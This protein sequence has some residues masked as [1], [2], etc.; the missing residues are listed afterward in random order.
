[1]FTQCAV[2]Q[3]GEVVAELRSSRDQSAALQHLGTV[4]CVPRPRAAAWWDFSAGAW[5]EKPSAPHPRAVWDAKHKVWRQVAQE[6]QWQ[7]VREL[8]NSLLARSDWTALPDTPLSADQRGLWMAY[9]Q[10]LR[11]VTDQADPFNI[12]WPEPP[13]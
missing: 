12:V 11:D 1:M 7:E 9:R 2:D 8:R 3:D 5:V 6:I 13:A 4:V 10:A